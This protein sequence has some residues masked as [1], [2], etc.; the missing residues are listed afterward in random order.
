METTIR[1]DI[2]RRVVL[3]GTPV[4]LI[5]L[6]LGHPLL[7]HMNTIRMLTPIVGW[8]IVLHVLLIPLFALMGYSMFLL[9]QGIQSLAA[10]ISRCATVIFV[11]FEVGY[12][13]A[14]G[15]NSGILVSN[16]NTLPVA[17]QSVIQQALHQLFANPAIFVSY[18]ILFGAGIVA[19][20]SAA[21]ALYSVGVPRLPLIILLGTLLS[22]YSHAL[23]FGPLGSACF[24]IAALW[25]ELV[26]RK[27]YQVEMKPEVAVSSGAIT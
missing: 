24:L 10:T 22:T 17:Q 3:F 21:W 4:V 15:L 23:P 1:R 19:V 11:A 25:I 16:A 20:C 6:E 8:W 26:W 2:L 5:I 27:S 14:V 13:T 18:Y 9:L 7:D 12:D